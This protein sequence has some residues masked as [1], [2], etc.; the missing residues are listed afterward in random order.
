MSANK[1]EQLGVVS[2]VVQHE[3]L[4]DEVDK[5]ITSRN[6][7]GPEAVQAAKQLA[8]DVADKEIDSDLL[9]DT[10]ERIAAIRVSK[11]GQEGL[12]AFFEKR[13]PN[14]LSPAEQKSEQKPEIGH[15]D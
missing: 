6:A 15:K 13:Q 2:E 8:F 9:R 1:E 7:N 12:S 10:S 14:W 3:S 11:Q 4:E 5:M